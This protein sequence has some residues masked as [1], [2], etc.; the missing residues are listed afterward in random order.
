MVLAR[1]HKV[2]TGL[3]FNKYLLG[4]LVWAAVAYNVMIL[5][6]PNM[7]LHVGQ[8]VVNNHHSKIEF[9]TR[10]GLKFVAE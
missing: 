7:I 2:S 1:H 4:Y 6:R 5:L 10:T 9:E 8:S 3:G